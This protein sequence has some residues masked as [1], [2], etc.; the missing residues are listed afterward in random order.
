MNILIGVGNDMRGDDAIGPYVARRLKCKG[1]LAIDCGTAPENFLS[2][3]RKAEPE[4]V[5]IVDSAE[6]G[7]KPG[8][9]R[10]IPKEKIGLLTLSTHSIPLSLLAEYI[11]NFAQRVIIVGI[12]P[13]NME[14]GSEMCDAVKKAGETLIKIIERSAVDEIKEV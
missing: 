14:F 13:A 8:D 2:V 1:W 5:V 4:T 7:L 11:E 9:I 3:I 12:Q 10:K 6:M